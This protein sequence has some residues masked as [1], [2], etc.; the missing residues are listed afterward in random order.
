MVQSAAAAKSRRE[1]RRWASG[2]PGRRI[3]SGARPGLSR[4]QRGRI[5]DAE[6]AELVLQA[7]W[8]V[9]GEARKSQVFWRI[10]TRSISEDP[11]IGIVEKL[12]KHAWMLESRVATLQNH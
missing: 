7:L 3:L 4:F 6:A 10:P 1:S 5:R 11:V 8:T 12:E 9:I 2:P